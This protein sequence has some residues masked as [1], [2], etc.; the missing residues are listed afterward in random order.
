MQQ[1]WKEILT[2]LEARQETKI[3]IKLAKIFFEA[4]WEVH[5]ESKYRFQKNR[6]YEDLEDH[7]DSITNNEA[8]QL[9]T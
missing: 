2:E 7:T 3:D 8:K 4:G 9:Y 6:H 5:P 1:I